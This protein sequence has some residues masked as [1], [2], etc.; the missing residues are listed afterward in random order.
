MLWRNRME[1]NNRNFV[2]RFPSP[3]LLSFRAAAVLSTP[4]FRNALFL[5]DSAFFRTPRVFCAFRSVSSTPA[6]G[7]LL[8][9]LS[10]PPAEAR[11]VTSSVPSVTSTTPS[12][13]EAQ[14]ARWARYFSS[15]SMAH[16]V[17]FSAFRISSR[18]QL[19]KR[20]S[21][22]H[23]FRL[24]LPDHRFQKDHLP[25]TASPILPLNAMSFTAPN[26]L[27]HG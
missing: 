15:P 12:L 1:R 20:R 26:A 25:D 9:S 22:A 16:S 19:C 3:F 5:S 8:R 23:S 2:C 24:H 7:W 14:V 6:L 13:T 11:P 27:T 21:F 18:I 4:Q 17:P 10:S